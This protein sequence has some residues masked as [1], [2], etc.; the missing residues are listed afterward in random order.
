MALN[1][2]RFHTNINELRNALNVMWSVWALLKR[3]IKTIRYKIICRIWFIISNNGRLSMSFV[4]NG[5]HLLVIWSR[6]LSLFCVVWLWPIARIYI[7]RVC[8]F[9]ISKIRE[10]TLT[11]AKQK[12]LPSKWCVFLE[13][14]AKGFPSHS[15]CARVRVYRLLSITVLHHQMPERETKRDSTNC[16]WLVYR[17]VNQQPLLRR[18]SPSPPTPTKNILKALQL[19]W[20]STLMLR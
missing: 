3:S 4:R 17:K 1:T 19:F 8:W 9:C 15:S 14:F 5:F 20:K 18:S 12:Y 11:V 6:C 2:C 10:N 7:I 16:P 13:H